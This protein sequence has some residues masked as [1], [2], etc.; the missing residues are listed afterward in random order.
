MQQAVTKRNLISVVMIPAFRAREETRLLRFEGKR[1]FRAKPYSEPSP[2][3]GPNG[4]HEAF[5]LGLRSGCEHR[6][7]TKQRGSHLTK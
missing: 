1:V 2:S 6:V 3:L 5:A 7:T 4:R